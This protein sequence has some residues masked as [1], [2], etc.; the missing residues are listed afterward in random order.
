MRLLL[1]LIPLFAFSSLIAQ[2]APAVLP[3]KERARVMNEILEERVHLLLPSL[4]K[5]TEIDCWV[6]ISREYNEDPVLRT[7]LPAEWLNARRRTILVI[8]QPEGSDELGLYAIARYDVG[9]LFKKSWDKEKQPDQWQA[10]TDLLK[11]LNP[12]KI[13]INQSE[14]W[15]LADGIVATDRMHFMDYLQKNGLDSR[16]VSAEKLAVAWLETRT[17]REMAIY[18]HVVEIAHH[19][20]AEGFS[21]EVI[22]PGV[23]STEDVQWW[24]RDRIRKLGLIA[25][26]HPSVDVQRATVMKGYESDGFASRPGVDIIQ[27]GDLVHVDFGITYL[28]LN[29]DTQQLAYVLNAGEFE[30]PAFLQKALESGMAVQDDLTSSFAVGKT[31]NQVLAEALKKG[32]DAGRRPWI[33]TH[34]IGYHGHAAGTTIGMWDA[35]EGVPGSGDYP[36]RAN[37]AYSIELNNTIYVEEWGK[38]VRIM[39]EEDAFFDGEKVTYI[40][41]RAKKLMLIPRQD[42]YLGQ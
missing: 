4:M 27:R 35:Q 9:T 24:Y 7:F 14:H 1:L 29:T 23:T 39:L 30:A 16:V 32:K 6:L 34:P 40:N 22:T 15:G 13:G 20:I 42:G 19:I 25:W 3:M 36:L 5:E 38:D 37:T 2:K 21:S 41:G 28:R 31:G 11:E 10:L 17:E 8:H 18:R 26:F 33:Y 12:E